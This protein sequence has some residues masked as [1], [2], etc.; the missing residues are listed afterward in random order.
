MIS[1]PITTETADTA[2]VGDTAGARRRL[3]R[4]APPTR[5]RNRAESRSQ[6]HFKIPALVPKM[7]VGPRRG[8]SDGCKA[9]F[10]EMRLYQRS[11]LI[12][13]KAAALIRWQ[14]DQIAFHSTDTDRVDLQAILLCGVFG[15]SQ[16][17]PFEILA[18]RYQYEDSVASRTAAKC[19]SRCQNGARDIRPATRNGVNIDRIQRLVESPI[20][21]R[22]R[23]GEKSAA[24]E[25]HDADPIAV[26]LLC[27]VID[28]QL[29]P[30][31]S[32]GLYI[33]RQH[34]SRRI[35]RE[36]DLIAA[37]ADFLPVI[38][39]QRTGERRAKT[40]YGA[41][42]EAPLKP[43]ADPGYRPGKPS[44]QMRRDECRQGRMLPHVVTTPYA[45]ERKARQQTHE[46]PIGIAEPHGNLRYL[47][48]CKSTQ[49]PS[50]PSEGNNIH[51]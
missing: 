21:D 45:Y 38:S 46:Q 50:S 9:G 4:R 44:S 6:K 35:D 43:A 15:R 23:T 33:G 39:E 26:Q 42:E 19:R 32:V 36:H 13:D 41:R 20:V 8:G 30:R 29:S 51:L 22:Q 14:G 10:V 11:F 3:K 18:I 17:V 47:V 5:L 40:D 25:R 27:H 12:L 16:S 49:S 37:A 7:H 28:R 2:T 31:Q 24:C 34:T 48:C 1:T